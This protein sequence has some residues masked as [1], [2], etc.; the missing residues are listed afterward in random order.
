MP[1]IYREFSETISRVDAEQDLKYYSET[2]GA[3]MGYSWP[4]FEVTANAR[5][6]VY[7]CV[8]M[9]LL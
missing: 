3:G 2:F 5:I 6:Y 1:E 4:D 9:F 7:Q 8:R